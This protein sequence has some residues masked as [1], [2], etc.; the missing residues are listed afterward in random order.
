M[1]C[2]SSTGSAIN[3][4]VQNSSAQAGYLVDFTARVAGFGKQLGLTQ[5]QIMGFGTVMDE[6]LLKDEMAATAFGNMLTKMQTDTE[7]FARIAGMNVKEFMD[8]LNKDANGAVLA[9]ADSLKKADPQTM[10]K[11]LVLKDFVTQTEK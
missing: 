10:M 6:N 7:K 11:M 1:W 3:E 9:L 2:A 8:L 5:A 4:L